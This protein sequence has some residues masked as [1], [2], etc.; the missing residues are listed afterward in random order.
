MHLKLIKFNSERRVNLVV[1][2]KVGRTKPDYNFKG[3]VIGSGLPTTL[4][5]FR[6]LEYRKLLEEED[7]VYLSDAQKKSL[8]VYRS[9]IDFKSREY[10][11][12]V[13]INNA[14]YQRT[15]RLNS[16][17]RF[18]LQN[19]DKVSFLTMTFNDSI[20]ASTSA[21]TRRKYIIR[22][23][24]SFNVPYV[25]NIDYGLKNEREH[26]HAV[27]ATADVSRHAYNKFVPDSSINF[28]LIYNNNSKALA[29]YINKLTNHAIKNTTK[30]CRVI[31]SR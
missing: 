28:K 17:I 6:Y 29:K 31:Y 9:Q 15:K 13:R 8:E 25:A 30:S 22:F 1:K 21:E 18:I 11:E 23:L 14:S 5:K 3:I 24:K 7:G 19:N 2:M 27:I 4:G 12:A 16:K 26:Y 20:L 10:E